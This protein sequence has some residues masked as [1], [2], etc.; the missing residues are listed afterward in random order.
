MPIWGL[1]L[2]FTIL[3][4]FRNGKDAKHSNRHNFISVHDIDTIFVCMVRFSGSANTLSEISTE[5]RQL[6][7]Q[8][9]LHKYKP[10][11]HKVQFCARNRGLFRMYNGG[12]W[13]CEFMLCEFFRKLARE[14]PLQ[15]N[16]CKNK[17]KL[18]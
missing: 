14:L 1:I 15:K 2:N 8:L 5:Q 16:F 13:V 4:I 9:N 17:T 3:T 6:P 12:Y 18:H 10:K 11:L 7:W